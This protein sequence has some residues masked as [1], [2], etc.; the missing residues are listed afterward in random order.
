MPHTSDSDD[1]NANQ[2]QGGERLTR[3]QTVERLRGLCRSWR[4]LAAGYEIR[5][6]RGSNDVGEVKRYAAM[7]ATMLHCAEA[8]ETALKELP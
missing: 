3:A 8:L 4:N 6:R 7:N 1:M 5:G 2:P